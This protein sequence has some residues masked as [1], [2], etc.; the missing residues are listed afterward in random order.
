MIWRFK[1]ISHKGDYVLNIIKICI[2]DQVTKHSTDKVKSKPWTNVHFLFS[3]LIPS[4]SKWWSF[5]HIPF[6]QQEVADLSKQAETRLSSA[7]DMALSWCSTNRLRLQPSSSSRGGFQR[8]RCAVKHPAEP[9]AVCPLGN[10]LPAWGRQRLTDFFLC[11][12]FKIQGN[13]GF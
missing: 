9:R 10:N 4:L 7:E 11:G 1:G 3:I 6:L 13:C 2:S 8:P 12:M 5:T